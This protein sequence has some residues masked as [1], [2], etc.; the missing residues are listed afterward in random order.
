MLSIF[1]WDAAGHTQAS[2]RDV[3]TGVVDICLIP[4]VNFNL[5]GG[6]GL[7]VYVQSLL[8]DKG[9]CVICVAEGAGQVPAPHLS[10]CLLTSVISVL[11]MSRVTAVIID[12]V[13]FDFLSHASAWI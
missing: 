9:H 1:R 4:E 10:S 13:A 12:D 8:A 6:H 7:M 2:S 11:T 3:V 5:D